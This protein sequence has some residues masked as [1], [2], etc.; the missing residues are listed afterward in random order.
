MTKARRKIKV[1]TKTGDAGESSLYNME[2]LP[3]VDQCFCALGDADELNAHVGLAR[4]HCI[5]SKID[6]EEKL[7]EIQ[8][9]L[10][11]VGSAIATPLD[12]STET[13]LKRAAFQWIDTL[14]KELPPLK[15]FILPGGGFA[16]A[17]LHVARTVCRRTPA[18]VRIYLN[19]LSDFFF[20]AARYAT[21]ISG[22]HE[23]V[24]KKIR[25]K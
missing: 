14:D 24:Y 21:Q 1:Y 4:E 7:A 12:T 2:R 6:L 18:S 23:V 13:Q 16:A 3:K 5:A 9:R 10:L 22:H 25:Q 17:Q 19:R 15:N 8:S 20:V 11:D